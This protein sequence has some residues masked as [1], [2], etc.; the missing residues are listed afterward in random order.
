MIHEPAIRTG[1]SIS[2]ED[3]GSFLYSND[4]DQVVIDIKFKLKATLLCLLQRNLSTH[5]LVLLTNLFGP[6][7]SSIKIATNINGKPHLI[8]GK[9]ETEIDDEN[10]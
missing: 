2:S 4:G 5:K 6:K 3:R 1:K 9:E 8:D 10:T 7:S